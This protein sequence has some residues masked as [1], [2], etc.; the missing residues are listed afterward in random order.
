MRRYFEDFSIGE[1]WTSRAVT[2]TENDI[3]RYAREYDPQPMHADPEKAAAGRF[4]T[5][6]AS[7]WQ[8]AALSMR[9]FVEAGGYGETPMVGLGIDELR[10]RRPV[11]PGDTL[12][13]T[14]EVI[15]TEPHKKRPEYGIVRTKVTVSNQNDEA[16]MTLVSL[17]QVPC[18]PGE[19]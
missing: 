2:L 17:G 9:L 18:R 3:T 6:I 10:W 7:G 13:V 11:R 5:V 12:R 19:T 8:I 14:R 4:G 1:T 15:G 16:V